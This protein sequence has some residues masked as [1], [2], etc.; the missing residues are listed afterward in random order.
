MPDPI[1]IHIYLYAIYRNKSISDYLP[2]RYIFVH[3]LCSNQTTINNTCLRLVGWPRRFI[4]GLSKPRL[5]LGCAARE[6]PP[7]HKIK[8]ITGKEERGHAASLHVRSVTGCTGTSPHINRGCTESDKAY[9]AQ[10]CPTP[11]VYEAGPPF[12]SVTSGQSRWERRNFRLESTKFDYGEGFP[13]VSLHLMETLSPEYHL[14]K[15]IPGRKKTKKRGL[16]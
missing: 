6:K 14:T 2:D 7:G 13:I 1:I 11:F 10:C 12:V 16:K 3:G 9:V 8:I 5:R 15:C 4:N